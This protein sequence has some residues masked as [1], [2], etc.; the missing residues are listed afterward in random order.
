MGVT[1]ERLTSLQRTIDSLEGRV[2]EMQ[3]ELRHA[4][5]RSLTE[6]WW[7]NFLRVTPRNTFMSACCNRR[8]RPNTKAVNYAG[9]GNQY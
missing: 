5:R 8:V 7:R 9:T 3:W 4:D 1:K 2:Q 6:R